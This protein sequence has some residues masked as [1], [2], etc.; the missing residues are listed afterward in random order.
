M[1]VSISVVADRVAALV[2]GLGVQTDSR[3]ELA[4][5]RLIRWL[6]SGNGEL[7]AV[8]RAYRRLRKGV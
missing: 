7:G 6:D 2:D 3:L 8:L 5:R 4:R 1:I